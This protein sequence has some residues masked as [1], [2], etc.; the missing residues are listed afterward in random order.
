MQF[1]T[2]LTEY[3]RHSGV[4]YFSGKEGINN[5]PTVCE[6]TARSPSPTKTLRVQGPTFRSVQGPAALVGSS[7]TLRS[8]VGPR[9]KTEHSYKRHSS[10]I[11]SDYSREGRP[12]KLNKLTKGNGFIQIE[13]CFWQKLFLTWEN[14]YN[15]WQHLHTVLYCTLNSNYTKLLF[16]LQSFFDCQVLENYFSLSGWLWWKWLEW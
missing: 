4:I 16:T 10:Y 15:S 2:Y 9:M 11:S 1:N 13:K 14:I 7:V 8:S 6:P 3:V 12:F 5:G